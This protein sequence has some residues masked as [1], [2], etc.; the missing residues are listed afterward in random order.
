MYVQCT[1]FTLCRAGIFKKSM[2]ARNQAGVGLSYRPARLHRLVDFIPWSQFLGSINVK[3][4]GLSMYRLLQL[5]LNERIVPELR[6]D[7]TP[8]T[9]AH[10]AAKIGLWAWVRGGGVGGSLIYD[11]SSAHS[12]HTRNLTPHCILVSW[13]SFYFVK[14]VPWAGVCYRKGYLILRGVA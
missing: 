2:G 7:Q 5:W 11:P 8:L 3:K 13:S 14:P 1:Y 10:L 12:N 4:C 9:L 6:E